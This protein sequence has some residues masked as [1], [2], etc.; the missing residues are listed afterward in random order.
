MFTSFLSKAVGADIPVRKSVCAG[1][2]GELAGG[3]KKTS[4]SGT[5]KSAN[6]RL[7]DPVKPNPTS[8]GTNA[9]GASMPANSVAQSF[10]TLVGSKVP[11]AVPTDTALGADRNTGTISSSEQAPISSGAAEPTSVNP[12][13]CPSDLVPAA[14]TETVPPPNSDVSFAS[15]PNFTSAGGGA[16][17]QT[18]RRV[19]ASPLPGC[20]AASDFSGLVAPTVA[21]TDAN[22]TVV[23]IAA[24]GSV[25]SYQQNSAANCADPTMASPALDGSVRG[26]EA[27]AQ[28]TAATENAIPTVANRGPAESPSCLFTAVP[29]LQPVSENSGMRNVP[30]GSASALRQPANAS[31]RAEPIPS[32]DPGT[33]TSTQVRPVL[34]QVHVVVESRAPEASQVASGGG[35]VSEASS[36]GETR[37]SE[38]H[39]HTPESP[40]V[41]NAGG[42]QDSSASD[43]PT[44]GATDAR[45]VAAALAPQNGGSQPGAATVPT[46]LANVLSPEPQDFAVQNPVASTTEHPGASTAENAANQPSATPVQVAHMVDGTSQAEMHIG[47]R[48][49]AFGSVEVHTVVRESQLGVTVGSEKGDL[50]SLLNSEV[51][52]LQTTF[53]QQELHFE[54]IR[55]LDGRGTDLSGGANQ[56]SR[57]FHQGRTNSNDGLVSDDRQD[58]SPEENFSSEGN[59]KLSV[60]A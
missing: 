58:I 29:A 37:P 31:F 3:Q 4:A 26:P 56:Q 10:S 47:L 27:E 44:Q 22:A 15:A 33:R 32:A 21:M 23:P 17:Y 39:P 12:L 35:K 20:S 40:R 52:I 13:V 50:R 42:N 46:S 28:P 8:L 59:S 16:A 48:T 2:A 51:P 54:N 41:T 49:Q 9:N 30:L 43:A 19:E 18:P 1:T 25:P 60:L 55:F 36:A 24:D 5:A 14:S 53:R 38:T 57:P 6:P 45:L 11:A 7:P 34:S